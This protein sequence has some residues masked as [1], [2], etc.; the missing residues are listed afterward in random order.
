M[1]WGT[2]LRRWLGVKDVSKGVFPRAPHGVGQL[3]SLTQHG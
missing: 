2:D 3:P 1:V